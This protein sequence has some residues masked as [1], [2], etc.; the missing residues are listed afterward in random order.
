MSQSTHW[1]FTI[2]NPTYDPEY[3]PDKMVYLVYQTEQGAQGTTHHQGFVSLKRS[4][5]LSYV[6]KLFPDSHLEPTKGTP[7]QASDYCKKAD[8]R[9]A[10]P[11]EFGIL[12][13][14]CQGK[15]S[16]LDYIIEKV[17][18]TSSNES[19]RFNATYIRNK[20]NIDQLIAE[21]QPK[22]TFK[23][24]VLW[25]HGSSG[26]GKTR[27][28]YEFAQLNSLSVWKG[29]PPVDNFWNDYHNQDI[30]LFDDFRYD[31][32]KFTNLLDY[33]DRYPVTI[34][35]KGGCTQLNSRFM[36]IVS[37][38]TPEEV[39]K[40]AEDEEMRQLLRRI[41]HVIHVTDQQIL[42]PYLTINDF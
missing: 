40:F 31:H 24:Y 19:I 28:V 20:R 23:P 2:N 16:D 17:R 22:R 21:I 8:T 15:R 29:R 5:R 12:S 1:C 25:I 41:D 6:V 42:L 35:L 26:V 39:Y 14:P 3:V 36:F 38:N 34:N 33:L 11:F 9:I 10:G 13:V 27:S 18:E 30:V 7:Q 4:Q 37:N 32:C